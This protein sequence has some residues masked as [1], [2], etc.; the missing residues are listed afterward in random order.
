MNRQ[1]TFHLISTAGESSAKQDASRGLGGLLISF[2]NNRERTQLCIPSN[3]ALPA[4][5]QDSPFLFLW[6]FISLTPVVFINHHKFLS[7]EYIIYPY[8]SSWCILFLIIFNMTGIHRQDLHSASFG[9]KHRENS[10]KADSI[11]FSELLLAYIKLS[12]KSFCPSE[13]CFLFLQLSFS[14]SILSS[15]WWLLHQ[16]WFLSVC[17]D[18]ILPAVKQNIFT[19]T[20]ESIF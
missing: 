10:G 16:P 7:V 18:Q 6:P 4:L 15:R 12:N 9:H 19:P 11:L 8:Y 5:S 13:I 20:E 17:N 14:L 2:L 3:S 1:V